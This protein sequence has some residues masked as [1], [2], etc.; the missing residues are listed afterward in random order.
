VTLN[1]TTLGQVLNKIL[2]PLQIKYE[3]SGRQI[4]LDA[5][6]PIEETSQ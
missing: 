4:V 3:I 6:E 1:N 2:L 5:A